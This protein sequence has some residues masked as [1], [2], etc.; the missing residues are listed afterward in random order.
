VDTLH[1]T[2]PRTAHPGGL[3]LGGQALIVVGFVLMTLGMFE[4]GGLFNI[5]LGLGAVVAGCVAMFAGE[6]RRGLDEE[7]FLRQLDNL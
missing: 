2:E 5:V 7:A 4:I 1:R 6:N 3:E